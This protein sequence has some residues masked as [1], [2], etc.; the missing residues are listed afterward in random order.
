MSHKS[1]DQ[2]HSPAIDAMLRKS[3]CL[4][5]P[6]PRE[7]GRRVQKEAQQHAEFKHGAE[8]AR[9]AEAPGHEIG[10]LRNHRVHC[11]PARCAKHTQSLVIVRAAIY[12]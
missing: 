1:T 8:S 4:S 7:D 10:L 3:R 9:E 6:S 5:H 11:I 2:A 12:T